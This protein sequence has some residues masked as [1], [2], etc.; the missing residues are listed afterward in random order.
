[1]HGSPA[2]VFSSALALTGRDNVELK[3]ENIPHP[4]TLSW[5]GHSAKEGVEKFLKLLCPVDVP[6][7][8]EFGDLR[9]LMDTC[10]ATLIMYHPYMQKHLGGQHDRVCLKLEAV[11]ED[12]LIKD[13]SFPE[14][15]SPR[16][17]LLGWSKILPK[18]YI[19]ENAERP[20][21]HEDVATHVRFVADRVEVAIAG[22][23][24]TNKK[25]E[26]LQATVLELQERDMKKTSLLE[27]CAKQLERSTSVQEK[28][29]NVL[30]KAVE[31]IIGMEMSPRKRKAIQEEIVMGIEEAKASSNKVA[32]SISVPHPTN[33]ITNNEVKVLELSEVKLSAAN[34]N[35]Q[36][37]LLDYFR[38]GLL[39][40]LNENDP[41]VLTN[42]S[43]PTEIQKERS[44]F[45]HCMEL[46]SLCFRKTDWKIV[47]G[48]H[49]DEDNL[50][51]EVAVIKASIDN[52][53]ELMLRLE[54]DLG[55]KEKVK[56]TVKGTR[57]KM[58]VTGVGERYRVWKTKADKAAKNKVEDTRK[59]KISANGFFGGKQGWT[60]L[61]ARIL[62]LLAPGTGR[63]ANEVS[64][65]AP[66]MFNPYKKSN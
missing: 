28:L 65:Q 11:A 58:T 40:G 6:Q 16:E 5:L 9:R 24:D 61:P 32:R 41:T 54:E 2:M 37:I 13:Q 53:R 56:Q 62:S 64:A 10:I 49:K 45:K 33:N 43:C 50:E 14:G 59:E 23:K 60:I 20:G 57:V 12:A 46:L 35:L 42:L 52:A 27:G 36:E 51:K 25:V 18:K 44:K 8:E 21:T 55:L 63:A 38:H 34:W 31:T 26:D 1:M 22:T 47:V 15:T 29:T 4:P 39:H 3:K 30:L 19:A 48:D 7:L 17:V 66:P